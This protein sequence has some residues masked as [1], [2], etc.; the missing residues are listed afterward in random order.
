MTDTQPYIKWLLPD[1]RPAHGGKGTWPLPP[2]TGPGASL[3]VTGPLVPCENGL[4]LCRLSDAPQWIAEGAAP[5][6][7]QY[8]GELLAA[9]DKVVVREARL[10]RPLVWNDRVARLFAADCAERALSRIPN[11]DP[12]SHAAVKAARMLA[13]G[14]LS[15]AAGAAAWSAA[16]AAAGAAAWAAAGAAAWSAAAAVRAAAGSAAAAAWAAA[17]AAAWSAAA[18]V[19]AAAG[20]AER[21]WQGQR[22]WFY[23]TGNEESV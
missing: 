9:D 23:L 18:A 7:V 21:E 4:H 17:G 10:I 8:R 22:L 12:R 16:G 6:L 13:R 5:Y 19:R 3:S 14:Q 20:A 2:T 11:A 1:G 15:D